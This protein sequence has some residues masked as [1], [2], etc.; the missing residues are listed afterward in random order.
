MAPL[1]IQM[2]RERNAVIFAV[3]VQPRASRDEI[4]GELAGALKIR[5]QAPAVEDRAN[6]ALRD[7]LASLLKTPKSAVRILSGE[8]SRTKRVEIQGV[9]KARIEAL[10][11]VE[12]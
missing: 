12:A 7:F 11:N 5:L 1:E 4:T 9:T 8:R 3:R 6:E 2:N 10:L